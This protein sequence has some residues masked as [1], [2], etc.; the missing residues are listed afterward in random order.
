MASMVREVPGDGT[1]LLGR[2]G[3]LHLL[4]RHRAHSGAERERKRRIGRKENA[5]RKLFCKKVSPR[6]PLPKTLKWLAEIP[7]SMY[8]ATGDVPVWIW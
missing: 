6:T 3:R 2:M 4:K 8:G 7:T 1:V 5:G